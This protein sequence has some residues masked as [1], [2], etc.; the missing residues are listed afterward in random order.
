MLGANVGSGA[1]MSTGAALPSP[2][3]EAATFG[4]PRVRSF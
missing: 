3:N 2:E 1:L 4:Y